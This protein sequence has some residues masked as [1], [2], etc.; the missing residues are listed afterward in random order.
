L[1]IFGDFGGQTIKKRDKVFDLI[2]FGLNTWFDQINF[3]M[4]T[5]RDMKRALDGTRAWDEITKR[6]HTA[7]GYPRLTGWYMRLLSVITRLL[8]RL[9]WPIEEAD[10]QCWNV[11]MV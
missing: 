9:I 8:R 7:V 6:P 10:S 5:S 11:G 1:E 4:T 2:V 3:K